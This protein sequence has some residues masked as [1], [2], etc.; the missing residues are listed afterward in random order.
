MKDS[1]DTFRFAVIKADADGN[2]IEASRRQLTEIG[3]VK[4]SGHGSASSIRR[5]EIVDECGQPAFITIK[6]DDILSIESTDRES[7]P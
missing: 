3:V 2:P 4:P 1:P 7:T 5:L 6:H